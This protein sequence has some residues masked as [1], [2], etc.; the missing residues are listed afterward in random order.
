MTMKPNLNYD[1]VMS[2]IN[3]AIYLIVTVRQVDSLYFA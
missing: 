3:L 1:R 2:H